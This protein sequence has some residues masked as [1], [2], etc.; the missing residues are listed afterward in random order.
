[1]RRPDT[2][3]LRTIQAPAKPR[4]ERRRD[5]LPARYVSLSLWLLIACAGAAEAKEEQRK[6]P[7][8]S[9]DLGIGLEYDSNVSVEE[10]DSTRS[11]SDYALNLDLGLELN[12]SLT[13]KTELAVT[14]DFAQTNYRDFSEVDRQTHILGTDLA[15]D[16]D[17][18]DSN[19]SL[20]YIHS[21]L[22]GDKFLE[23]YR[24][25]PALSGFLAKKWFARGAYVY[26]DKSIADRP[27]R[28][29][30]THAGEFDLYYFLRG[31]RSYFNIGYRYRDE[32]AVAEELDY[33]SHSVKLRYIQRFELFARMTKLELAWRYEDR[34][35]G[36][37][38]PDIG[39]K[40][41]DERHRWRA[42][43]E[44]PLWAGGALQ[45]YYSHADYNSN[46]EPVD[47]TQDIAGTR[48]IYRW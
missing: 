24:V 29:A 18:L 9:A 27:E 31:L 44:I 13:E 16:L 17:K 2:T 35:Y 37:I 10:I 25:S 20:F 39:E 33:Q 21:R 6:G 47:Y 43:Y 4:P 38:H 36:S 42:D 11:E 28:D 8:F 7:E 30:E 12:Q 34:D 3:V 14:Y 23:L 26:L 22:D 45:L 46:Y 32:D 40:R 19:L 48:F 1:M 41:A 15:W 5:R